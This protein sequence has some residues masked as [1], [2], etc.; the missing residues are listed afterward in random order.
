MEIERMKAILV[1]VIISIL[2]GG[3]LIEIAKADPIP[4]ID[5]VITINS[6][7]NTTFNVSA[8]EINFTAASNWDFY[9][10]YYSLDG[11]ELKPV[12]NITIITQENYNKAHNFPI[13]RTTIEGNFSLSNLSN[14]L[15]NVTVYDVITT[16][17]RLG[18]THYEKGEP[19]CSA[20]YSFEVELTLISTPTATTIVE[21]YPPAPIDLVTILFF[22]A[23]AGVVVVFLIIAIRHRKTTK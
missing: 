18:L 9:S 20:N 22:S 13:Y 10:Y 2:I 14:G 11:Q 4:Q 15:H 6:P 19:I 16:D 3:G 23:I 5:P 7:Q 8:I 12:S 17:F 1:V 21:V